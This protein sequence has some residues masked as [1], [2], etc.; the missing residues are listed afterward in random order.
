MLKYV[1]DASVIVKWFSKD[2]EQERDAAISVNDEL[3]L[4]NIE[5]FAPVFLLIEAVNILH[6]KKR[7]KRNEVY[8]VI[9]ELLKIGI[10]FRSVTENEVIQLTKI[11][12][13][14]SITMYDAQYIYLAKKLDCKL[15]TFDDKLLAISDLCVR[16]PLV[17]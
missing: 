2:N 5:L 15:V 9:K 3:I 4:G 12:F 8:S 10:S 13:D 16:P 6:K 14:Y 17:V 7:L 1:A 11:A